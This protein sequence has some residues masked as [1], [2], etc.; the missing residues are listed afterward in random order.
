MVTQSKTTNCT[1]AYTW[2]TR[3]HQFNSFVRRRGLKS[4][5]RSNSSNS[6]R[7]SRKVFSI[8]IDYP[9]TGNKTLF[10][11]DQFSQCS[12]IDEIVGGTPTSSKRF[13]WC[14]MTRC[15]ERDSS[16]VFT[17]KFFAS[18]QVNGTSL[19]FY[20]KD[21]LGSVRAMTDASGN[22]QSR[23]S[24][25]PFGRVT[26]V[27]GSV[28]SDF[29]YAGMYI[30]PRSGLNLTLYR[31]Y[32]SQIGRWLSPDPMGDSQ[33]SNRSIYVGNNPLS[34][35]DA[36]G[37][38][39]SFDIKGDTLIIKVPLAFTG[40]HDAL[41][42]TYIDGINNFWNP[43]GLSWDP[44]DGGGACKVKVEAVLGAV[45]GAG[46][47]NKITVL[48]NPRRPGL[49]NDTARN[50]G[51]WEEAVMRYFGSPWSAAHEIG[52]ILGLRDL[53][54]TFMNQYAGG[55]GSFVTNYEIAEVMKRR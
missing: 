14:N 24:F 26:D 22:V 41:I 43:A 49:Q 6:S 23:N 46:G 21:G 2:Y 38:Y 36:L 30:H 28:F 1:A 15:E 40:A 31:A 7:H 42:A 37:L 29:Q 32:N 5:H 17:K 33:G 50:G 51:T 54:S 27:D 11:L 8:E 44:G 19:Y 48:H 18:G 9:G 25:D 53:E 12:K 16:G 10:G 47:I 35:T 34:G 4:R 20:G 3:A 55:P 45:E 39:A 52:H 13:I